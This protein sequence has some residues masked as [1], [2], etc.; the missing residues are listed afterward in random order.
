M[1]ID[2][3]MNF[4]KKNH[5]GLSEV[6]V[7]HLTEGIEP[8]ILVLEYKELEENKVNVVYTPMEKLVESF[9]GV[10]RAKRRE[11]HIFCYLVY[12]DFTRFVNVPILLSEQDLVQNQIVN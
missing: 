8:G 12:K 11:G 7:R 3:V 10:V 6:F 5:S 9:R 4:V 2:D 1:N